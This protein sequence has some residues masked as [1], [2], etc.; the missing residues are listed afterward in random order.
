MQDS[1]LA[2]TNALSESQKAALLTLLGD[3]DEA[4]HQA[5]RARVL[6]LGAAAREWLRPH[7]CSRNRL[8]AQRVAGILR[9]LDAREAHERFWRFCL[10]HCEHF[11]IEA[12]AWMLAQT[13]YP[14]INVEGYQ[15]LLDEL[16]GELRPRIALY[17]RGNQI[18]SRINEHLFQEAGF[19][20]NL[21]GD[22]EPDHCYLNRVLD[23]RVGNAHTLSLLYIAVARRLRLPIAP[24]DLAG[25]CLCRYQTAAE[26]IYIDPFHHGRLL[27]RADC[28]HHLI[29]IHAQVKDDYLSPVSARHWLCR[30]CE[31]LAHLYEAA[32]R[33]EESARIQKYVAMLNLRVL[34]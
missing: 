22:D 26:E 15:A 10:A 14:E 23:R 12:A 11:D 19:E 32:N 18:L 34:A 20:G 27:S 28:V 24:V 9:E 30:L 6:S 4:V 21:E 8:L 17:R 13:A 3:E 31:H 33:P 29:R 25:H 5:V 2:P 16:A 1:T 7:A